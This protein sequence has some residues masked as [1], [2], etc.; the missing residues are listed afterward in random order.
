MNKPSKKIVLIGGGGHCKSCI[1]VIQA[2]GNYDITGILDL[3]SELGKEVMGIKV[4]GSDN[5]YLKFHKEGNV[6]LITVGQIKSPAIRK[7]IFEKLKSIG[8]TIETVIAP[9][10][11]V[12]A[13]AIIEEGSIVMHQAFVN[14][15]AKI[16]VNNIINTGAVLEHDVQVGDHNHF[17]TGSLTNGDCK[18]GNEN[19]IG[20]G[21][22]L[23]N[24]VQVADNIIIGAGAVV[25]EN[26]KEVGV[27]VGSPSKIIK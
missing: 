27:Y 11:Y 12:A 25:I 23:A 5:D 8:A 19:F 26:L 22:C 2:T 17:S 3:P 14:A 1:E 15:A 13:S 24:G 10:A 4:I 7:K 9:T 18:I 21:T 6:F 20:S 16:G